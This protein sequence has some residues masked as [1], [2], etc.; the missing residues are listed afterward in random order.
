LLLIGPVSDYYFGPSQYYGNILYP[1]GLDLQDS[2][3]NEIIAK[4]H[5]LGRIL[6]LEHPLVVTKG[7]SLKD[8]KIELKF[9]AP[10]YQTQRGGQL[11]LHL[12]GQLVIYPVVSLKK[13]NLSVREWV[14]FLQQV[15]YLAL[16]SIGVQTY[17]NKD[18]SGLWTDYGKI[19]FIGIR[20]QKGIS[21]HGL[22][23]NISNETYYYDQFVACGVKNAP[24][25]TLLLRG[26]KITL[27]NFFEIWTKYFL[28]NIKEV[29]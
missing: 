28:L 21:Y 2:V 25:D 27:A 17:T 19:V 11:A 29:K 20:V 14:D 12:P 13:L 5:F 9:Q 7:K 4:P 22:A 8:Q 10:I 1:Q 18:Q 16:Q 6:A 24:I 23:I 15:T 3:I 26:F